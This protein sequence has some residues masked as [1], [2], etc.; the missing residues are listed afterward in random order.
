M[1]TFKPARVER[2]LHA[3]AIRSKEVGD[4]A[5][6]LLILLASSAAVDDEA[7]AAYC[8]FTANGVKYTLRIEKKSEGGQ[9][10]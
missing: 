1:D 4:L 8:E 10:G 7:K 3:Q 2:I 6:E 9:Q 5:R